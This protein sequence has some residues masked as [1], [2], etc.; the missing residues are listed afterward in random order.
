MTQRIGDIVYYVFPAAE[1][2]PNEAE[3]SAAVVVRVWS[4][5][6]LNLRVISDNI[7]NGA[8]WRTSVHRRDT[9]NDAEGFWYPREGDSS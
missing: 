9:G 8:E 7:S 4:D 3:F 2:R 6:M 5:T 1:H